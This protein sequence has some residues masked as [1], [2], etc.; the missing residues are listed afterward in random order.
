MSYF[1]HF[2]GNRF[3]PFRGPKSRSRGVFGEIELQ[4]F[5]CTGIPDKKTG[6]PRKNI[7]TLEKPL[8]FVTFSN[9][10][11][12]FAQNLK[13]IFGELFLFIAKNIFKIIFVGESRPAGGKNPALPIK[14]YKM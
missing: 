10:F 5:F 9:G 8:T 7:G 2:T 4:T 14:A 12:Y 11:C 3:S 13:I 1:W 6:I